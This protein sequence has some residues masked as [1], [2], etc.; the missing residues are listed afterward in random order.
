MAILLKDT[1]A[2]LMIQF[3][4]DVSKLDKKLRQDVH[5]PIVETLTQD[6]LNLKKA[7][8]S[9]VGNDDIHI[10]KSLPLLVRDI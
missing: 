3:T 6:N 8:I 5:G 1:I 7:Y 4:E 2:N 9:I 10:D